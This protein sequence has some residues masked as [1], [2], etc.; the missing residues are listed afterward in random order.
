M[1]GDAPKC[2]HCDRV[3]N[4]P[5]DNPVNNQRH[6][7]SHNKQKPR[8]PKPIAGAGKHQKIN[9]FFK[10][11]VPRV[12]VDAPAVDVTASP[13]G[14]VVDIDAPADVDSDSDSDSSGVIAGAGE[15]KT[16]YCKGVELDIPGNFYSNFPFHLL[17]ETNIVVAGERLHEKSCAKPF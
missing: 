6:I 13:I 5:G 7:G 15:E 9:S 10:P 12:A 4:Q 17:P 14:D 1:P 2:P 16:S 11:P 8:K 3:F